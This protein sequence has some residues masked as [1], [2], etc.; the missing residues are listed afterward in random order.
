MYVRYASCLH[1][2]H[3]IPRF[4]RDT[5]TLNTTKKPVRPTFR[6]FRTVSNTRTCSSWA[7][8]NAKRRKSCRVARTRLPPV[9]TLVAA[10]HRR[11]TLQS[12]ASLEFLSGGHRRVIKPKRPRHQ[13]VIIFEWFPPLWS[14]GTLVRGRAK[15]GALLSGLAEVAHAVSKAEER[16]RPPDGTIR[17]RPLP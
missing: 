11:P 10:R 13:G 3:S 1:G 9:N 2:R 7:A 5:C 8:Y 4:S 12:F 17:Q 15:N 6:V 16:K 14:R